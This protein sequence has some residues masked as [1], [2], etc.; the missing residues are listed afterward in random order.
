[1]AIGW[2]LLV[3]LA[4]WLLVASLPL[5]NGEAYYYA[6]SRFPAWSYYDH[7]PLIAWVVRA[8]TVFGSSPR[9]VRLGPVLAAAAFG[10]LAYRLA[11]RLYGPRAAFFSLVLLTGLPVFLGSS[12]VVN[13]E[14]ALAPLWVAF[15][16]LFEAMRERDGWYLPLGAGLILGLAFLAKYTA[17][18]LIP[19]ALIYTIAAPSMRRWVSRP[20]FYV[21]GLAAL[22]VTLP[23]L[24]WNHARGWP[25]LRLHFLERAGAVA[26]PIA[27][28]NRVSQLIAVSST[29]ATGF[30]GSLL[31]VLAGQLLAYSPVLAPLLVLSLFRSLRRARQDDA[32]RFVTAFT[33]PILLPLLAVMLR[34]QDAEPHWT[35]MALVPAA[36]VTARWASQEG[37]GAARIRIAGLVGVALTGVLFVVINVHARS[38]LLMHMIPEERY[39]PR[40]DMI[41]ELVGWDEVRPAVSSAVRETRGEVSLA[42]SHY[43]LCGRLL[44][45]T[46]D[47][48]AVYCPTAR[49]T[50]FDFFDRRDPPASSTVIVLTN[51]VHEELPAGLRDRTCTLRSHVEIERGGRRIARYFVHSCAPRSVALQADGSAG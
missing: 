29:N 7:P 43:S 21:G 35:M 12:F 50:A 47:H 20:S 16:V 4:R 39:E 25:S 2:T 9:A 49:R 24:I 6:W 48:P 27:G 38:A 23:V 26:I 37:A 32:D 1:M 22:L 5:G 11:E 44:F 45:E 19:A 40:A 42:S 18:L 28:E 14:A 3:T 34:V 15:L 36:I 41:N 31:R 46:G 13:P 51:D 17:L 10:L 8:T 30:T 33:W